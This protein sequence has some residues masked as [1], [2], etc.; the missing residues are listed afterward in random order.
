MNQAVGEKELQVGG[1]KYVLRPGF[2]ALQEIETRTGRGLMELFESYGK[3]KNRAS[4][5][6]IIL[7]ACM[8]AGLPPTEVPP[9]FDSFGESIYPLGL[10]RIGHVA[11]DLLGHALIQGRK[12]EEEKKT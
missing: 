5:T 9:S 4:D 3:G 12:Q 11:I 1:R 8:K 7:Y 10:H 2:L 6:A